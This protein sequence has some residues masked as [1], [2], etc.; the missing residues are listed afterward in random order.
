V[1]AGP[2]YQLTIGAG[3]VPGTFSTY[4]DNYHDKWLNIYRKHQLSK[5]AEYL[6]L[7]DI[8]FD[9]PE[10]HVIKKG[11]KL[12]YAFYTHPWKQPEPTARVYR[13]GTEFD[14]EVQGKTE[15]RY[16]TENYSG[17]INFRG[18]DKD[19][20]YKVVDYAANKELGTVKGT[21]P[22]L[23]TS[24]NDFLLLEVSPVR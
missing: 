20:V 18:L 14:R 2:S 23:N 17:K 21:N 19:K 10:A 3:G 11:G 1:L 16:P 7:Y 8:G 22:Y 6:N 13:F 5:G 4:L 24:F 9:Y 15:L 12:Y